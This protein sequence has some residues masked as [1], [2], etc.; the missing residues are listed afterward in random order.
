MMTTETQQKLEYLKKWAAQPEEN[1]RCEATL[2]AV[3][4]EYAPIN[5]TA[6]DL[7]D[8]IMHRYP[9]VAEY[10]VQKN[11]VAKDEKR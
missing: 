9:K 11:K 3:I 5:P 4:A 7:T 1:A 10:L 6:E 2:K 8:I